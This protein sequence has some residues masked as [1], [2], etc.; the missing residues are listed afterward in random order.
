MNSTQSLKSAIVVRLI[1]PALM[2]I[3]LETIISYFVTLHY[4][5]EAYDRWLLDSA[6]SLVQE[7]KVAD[8]K[9][10][11]D[12][13]ASALEIFKWD[14]QDQTYFKVIAEKSGLLAGDIFVP[15]SF[16]ASDLMLPVFS[17]NIIRGQ[18]VR[19]VSMQVPKMN[20][21][22]AVYIHVAETLNK[23]HDMMIDILLADLVPQLLLILMIG[24]YLFKGVHWGLAPLH[25]LA[26]E[27]AQ[28]S[29]HDLSPIAETYI[30]TEVRTLMDTINQLLE[31]LSLAIASQQR[32]ISNAAHQLRTP[33]AGLKLQAERAQRETTVE[34]MQPA[35]RQ[36]QTSADRASHMVT[37]LLVLARSE[38]VAGNRTLES[39][40][41]RALVREVC[42]EWVPKA[43]K[44]QFDLSFDDPKQP[45]WIQGDAILLA[46]LLNNLIDNALAYGDSREEINVKLFAEPRVCLSVEN[47]GQSIPSEEQARI[48]ER[49]YRI[50]GSTGEGCG[51]GLAIVKEIAELH[52]AQVSLNS[53]T[54][55]DGVVVAVMFNAFPRLK[56]SSDSS[57]GQ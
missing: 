8:N 23:R 4:V 9:V 21:P 24:L 32:F 18:P 41:L 19:V 34:A 33:L 15:E 12:L 47:A 46:E 38:P 29:P 11:T 50:Q 30:F 20:M 26:D 45:V 16:V 52:Q 48:F 31:S 51:L 5:D 17:N 1:M 3:I 49:F 2:F 10:Y 37:Q 42:I 43:L 6:R 28:R 13:S 22:E 44:K 40:D 53:R 56:F 39:I 55:G 36:I 27:I 54:A 57:G 35:L 7:V 25:K 14:A